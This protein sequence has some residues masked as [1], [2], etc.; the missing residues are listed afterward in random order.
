MT[1]YKA[2][3]CVPI[4]DFVMGFDRKSR[5]DLEAILESHDKLKKTGLYNTEEA[6]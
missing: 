1:G 4:H 3:R 6:I 2:R 5:F